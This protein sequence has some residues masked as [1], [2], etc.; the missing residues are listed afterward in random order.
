MTRETVVLVHGLW[1]RGHEFAPM[2]GRLVREH[3][4]DVRVFSYPTLRG[5]ADSITDDLQ[6]MADGLAGAGPVH[7]VGHSLGGT[8]VH[9]LLDRAPDRYG[10]NAVVLGSP[11]SGCRAAV[12]VSRFR[13]LRPVIGPHL[14][15]E[16]VAPPQRCWRGPGAF[17]SIAGTL[18]A[19]TGQLFT[20]F[21]E[22]HDGTVAVRETR[23]PGLDDHLEVAHGHM[24]LVFAADVADQVAHFLRHRRFRR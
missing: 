4:Y 3:G 22:P 7:F 21:E 5:D 24:G 16:A 13:L 6:R 23:I 20:R 2:R 15:A 14:L 11:L 9:R 1:M 10:G 17:G 19:G 8:F 12:G 18:H